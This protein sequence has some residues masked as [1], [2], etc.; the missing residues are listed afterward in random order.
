[1]KELANSPHPESVGRVSAP[2]AYSRVGNPSLAAPNGVSRGLIASLLYCRRPGQARGRIV[3]ITLKYFPFVI[4]Y[5]KHTLREL[6]LADPRAGR[7]THL[8]FKRHAARLD[9]VPTEGA[10]IRL[11][12][13]RSHSRGAI[14]RNG[15][16]LVT[17]EMEARFDDI[18]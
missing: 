1:V 9:T 13:A 6:I 12:F 8:Y 7:L 10:A 11:A 17:P 18:A 15:T 4:R 2:L 14:F 3:A 5:G 16:H